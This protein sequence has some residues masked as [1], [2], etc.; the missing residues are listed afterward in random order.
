MQ[1]FA[2]LYIKKHIRLDWGQQPLIICLAQLYTADTKYSYIQK[3]PNTV[4]GRKVKTWS[5]ND[6]W[7]DS[8]S[9]CDT[10]IN[11]ETEKTMCNL[12]EFRREV[13]HEI[14]S[15][16]VFSYPDLATILV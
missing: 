15:A 10:G 6:H 8:S 11:I 13:N 4:S 14:I 16:N 12:N 3:Q 7:S 2:K 5:L 1:K 9:L